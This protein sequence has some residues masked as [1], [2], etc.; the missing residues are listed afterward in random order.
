MTPLTVVAILNAPTAPYTGPL[1]LDGIL[2]AG[3]GGKMGANHPGKWEA[4]KVV[5][6]AIES[7]ALPLARVAVKNHWWYAASQSLPVGREILRHIHRRLP[8]TFYERFTTAKTAN[9]ATGPDKSLRI[10]QYLRPEWMRIQWTCVGDPDGVADLLWRV[11]S[12]G[13][14][15]THG[16]GW[17]RQWLLS[18][19][20]VVEP[21]GYHGKEATF[22]SDAPP[23]SAYENNV[24]LRHIPVELATGIP[25][26]QV[27]RHRIPLRPPYHT[28]FDGDSS[29][30][31]PCWQLI[32][33][34]P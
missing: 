7:G 6:A 19:G 2:S 13:K 24:R 16:N 15:G 30:A 34:S 18:T 8:Q 33:V 23:L 26:G 10:P 28:G 5:A 20:H 31:I 27:R 22:P 12:V 14:Y 1:L 9:I 17:V 25:P 3:F 32:G 29:R 4:P 21:F 11:G